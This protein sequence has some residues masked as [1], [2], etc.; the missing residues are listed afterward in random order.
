MINLDAEKFDDNTRDEILYQDEISLD[1]W[2]NFTE[3]KE[4]AF[5]YFVIIVEVRQRYYGGKK[6]NK[7]VLDLYRSYVKCHSELY[8]LPASL[9]FSFISHALLWAWA[10]RG[11]D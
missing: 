5:I 4:K 3:K 1:V 11:G 10:R 8:Q 7:P 9:D 2:L 6:K